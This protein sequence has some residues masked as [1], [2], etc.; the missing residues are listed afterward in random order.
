MEGT[1]DVAH[2]VT[3]P[4]IVFNLEQMAQKAI[5]AGVV[6]VLASVIPRGP[7]VLQDPDNVKTQRLANDIRNAAAAAGIPFADPYFDLIGIPNL[8]QDYY[9]NALH[10]NSAGYNLLADSFINPTIAGLDLDLSL[11]SQVPPG[12][13]VAS[14][15]VLCLNQGRFRLETHWEFP[16]GQMG[17][18][19]ALPQTDDTGAFF[20]NNPENVE[21]IVKV[22]DGRHNNG[23]FWVFYG[24]LSNVEYTLVVTDTT[25]GRCRE[26]F[27]PQDN[28]ASVG[29]TMAF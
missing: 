25:D 1:N 26:Y 20:W 3:R 12:P 24:A 9:A 29:D 17:Q 14:S 10:P 8:F 16:N 11:C 6:P 15:T 21:M 5:A 27:N 18:G 2:R 13:C 23:F 4:T 28:F 7:G 19:Q 22:L